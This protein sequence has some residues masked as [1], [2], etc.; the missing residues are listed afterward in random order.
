[1]KLAGRA[2]QSLPLPH[3]RLAG[4]GKE[5][6]ALVQKMGTDY[7]PL[8]RLVR[9]FMLRRLKTVP[10]LLPELPPKTEQPAYCL[11]TPEQTRLYAR[12]VEKL[13]SII[14]EPDPQT[15]L[16]LLLPIL[17]HLKQICNHPAQYLGES[18]YDP[19]QSGKMTRLGYLARQIAAAGDAALI[20]T[21]YRSM[22]EPLHDFLAGIFGA[23]GLVLHGGTPIA[24][25]QRLVQQFQHPGGPP[26]FLLSLKAAGTGLTLTRARHVIHF[27]RW[28][29][30]AVENQASDRAYRIG[31]QNP[32]II[33]PLICRGTIEE[34]IHTMLTR[35]RDMAD[36]LLSGGLEKLLLHLTPEE[37]LA[38]IGGAP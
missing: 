18:Y 31:Q 17:S 15:R 37:L 21:Q 13:Q 25:R 3:P 32:V 27:D 35:K 14:H 5:F 8:R 19:A 38:L 20:F 29:N 7:T 11:L 36:K 6:N 2:A 26:F 22:M 23:P 1:G 12:E 33:H 34:N 24:E 16:T 10:G 9:P 30:P 4:H 28:W